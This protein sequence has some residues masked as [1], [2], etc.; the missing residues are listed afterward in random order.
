[1]V[2]LYGA[3]W[4]GVVFLSMCMI[5]RP[6]CGSVASILM[7]PLLDGRVELQGQDMGIPRLGWIGFHAP[8]QLPYHR[9]QNVQHILSGHS[10]ATKPV[11][12]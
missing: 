11:H 6:C 10:I 4:F 5:K 1:M 8:L 7:A 3:E 9:G 2:S 12:K